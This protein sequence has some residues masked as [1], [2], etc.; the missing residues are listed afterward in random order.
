MIPGLGRSPGEG[1]GYPLQYS[2]LE[3]SRDYTAE[4]QR[5][6]R[7]DKKAFLSDQCK[8]R[9]ENNRMGKTRDLFKKIR[10]T[11]GTFHAKMG[12]IKDKMVWT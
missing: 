4:F 11:K 3:N 7:R 1:K 12:S 6:A 10:D 5:I 8:E 2:G 9:E